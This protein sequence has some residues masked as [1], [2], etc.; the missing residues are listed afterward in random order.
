MVIGKYLLTVYDTLDSY[1]GDLHWWPGETPFEIIVGAIL[2]QNTNWKNVKI[3]IDKLKLRGLLSPERLFGA[4]GEVIAELIR[5][6]GYYNVKTRRLKALLQFL[7]E[8]YESDLE[9]MFE[10]ELWVLRDRLLSVNGIGEETADSILLYAGNKPIFVVDSYTRRILQR[11]NIIDDNPG[12]GE[13]Q[14]LF[15]THL[16]NNTRLFNQFHALIV[17]T[18]KRFCKRTPQCQGCP[19]ET[20]RI[21]VTEV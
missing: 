15:M 7:H 20:I 8:E 19:L 18:G 11:H 13:I 17:N 5:S 4:S 3:A 1:F 12:Y 2:T 9:R 6:S 16:P 21:E 10:E 14:K